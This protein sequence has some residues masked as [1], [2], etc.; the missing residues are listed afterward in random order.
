MDLCEIV[1][2]AENNPNFHVV[3]KHDEYIVMEIGVSNTFDVIKVGP[4]GPI[5]Y[6]R[7]VSYAYGYRMGDNIPCPEAKI[8]EDGQSIWLID[9]K[10]RTMAQIMTSK[11][12]KVEIDG[13]YNSLQGN[14][15]GRI[16]IDWESPFSANP[17]RA[18]ICRPSEGIPRQFYN[19]MD[20]VLKSLG[21]YRPTIVNYFRNLIKGILGR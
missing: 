15:V 4:D 10:H 3:E 5:N 20:K 16:G 11:K 12:V 18:N 9:G 6:H 8:H 2:L 21:Y 7:L 13:A 14:L 17:F 19:E 1:K